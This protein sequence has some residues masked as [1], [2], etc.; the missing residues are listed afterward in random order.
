MIW[1]EFEDDFCDDFSYL[2]SRPQSI[3]MALKD[4]DDQLQKLGSNIL[5]YDLPE[6]HSLL[7]NESKLIAEHMEYSEKAIMD[8]NV[9]HLMTSEQKMMLF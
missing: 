1:N 4:I 8:P 7:T 9:C 6:L 3:N 5:K 2:M